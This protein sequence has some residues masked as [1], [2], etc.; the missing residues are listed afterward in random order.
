MDNLV[1][2]ATTPREIAILLA[3]RRYQLGI[4]SLQIDAIAGIADGLTSK[5]EANTKPL[6]FVSLPNLLAAL[7]LK[8][9]VVADDA[10]LPRQTVALIGSSRGK[11]RSP[12]PAA[13][14]APEPSLAHPEPVDL[15]A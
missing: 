13:G 2:Y 12:A 4:T 6:G 14:G 10:S 5:I 7:G 8:V 15:A 11:P 3:R 1:G 9:A